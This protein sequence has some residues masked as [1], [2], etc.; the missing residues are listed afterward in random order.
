[1]IIIASPPHN[2]IPV[3]PIIQ[4]KQ[5]HSGDISSVLPSVCFS[6][7]VH[8]STGPNS[9]IRNCTDLTRDPISKSGPFFQLAVSC[10]CTW[11]N[12][13]PPD[14]NPIEPERDHVS[15]GDSS[16]A[17]RNREKCSNEPA[18][19]L[20]VV[21]PMTPQWGVLKV[22]Y[23]SLERLRFRLDVGDLYNFGLKVDVTTVMS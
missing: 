11:R 3:A 6:P 12:S 4:S 19:N 21:K 10:E 17:G 1:M 20:F 13:S 23:K 9:H 7:L 8:W 15:P 2:H 16:S 5:S 18:A 22:W 14:R